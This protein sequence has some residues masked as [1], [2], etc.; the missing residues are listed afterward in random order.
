MLLKLIEQEEPSLLAV[1]FDKSR[2]TFRNK[3]YDLY[4][5]QRE[6]TPEDLASQFSLVRQVLNAFD[7]P[8]FEHEDFEADDIIGTLATKRTGR[9]PKNPYCYR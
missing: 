5:A 2:E 9:R 7:L 4:K 3:R 8:Y 6:H 1:A